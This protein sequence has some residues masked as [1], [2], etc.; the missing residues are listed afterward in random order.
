MEFLADHVRLNYYELRALSVLP[1]KAREANKQRLYIDLDS[2]AAWSANHAGAVVHVFAPALTEAVFRDSTPGPEH[3][4][5]VPLD[6][7]NACLLFNG[8]DPESAITDRLRFDVFQHGEILVHDDRRRKVVAL[9]SIQFAARDDGHKPPAIRDVVRICMSPGGERVPFA[10]LDCDILALLS[11]IGEA[12]RF[13]RS[14]N[15]PSPT[16]ALFRPGD[17][18]LAPMTFFVGPLWWLYVMPMKVENIPSW[19]KLGTL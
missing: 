14:G 19:A 9:A 2:R 12:A 17:S 8:L 10:A 11:V 15:L 4:F 3:V 1:R 5:S 13:V 18:E 16:P 6:A 7:L